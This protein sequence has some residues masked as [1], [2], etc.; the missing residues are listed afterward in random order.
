MPQI[1]RRR[2]LDRTG[3]LK[4]ETG[5]IKLKVAKNRHGRVGTVRLAF[6]R[7]YTRFLP[8]SLTEDYDIGDD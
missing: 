3:A 8:L 5:V 7:E 1:I 6:N 2:H 4:L